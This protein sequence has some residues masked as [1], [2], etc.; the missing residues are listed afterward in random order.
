MKMKPLEDLERKDKRFYQFITIFSVQKL[1]RPKLLH[2][3]RV[4]YLLANNDTT[5]TSEGGPIPFSFSAVT[6]T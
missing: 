6:V 2:W 4:F 1:L 5:M 3:K